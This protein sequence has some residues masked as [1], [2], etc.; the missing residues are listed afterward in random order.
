[1]ADIEHG[2]IFRR[3]HRGDHLG[4][5]RLTAQSVALV[6]KALARK[7]GLDA[8]RNRASIFKMADQSRHR[9]LDVLREYVRDEDRCADHA[10]EGLLK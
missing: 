6:I 7:A 3:M 9:S 2:A 10:G 1:M 5:A 4:E 8:A